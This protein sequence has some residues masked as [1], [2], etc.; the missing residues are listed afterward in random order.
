MKFLIACL[1]NV[2]AQYADTRHNVGFKIADALAGSSAVSFR[3]ER[4]GDVAEVIFKGHVLVVLKPS[5]YMNLSGKAVRYWMQA[6]KIA[7]DRILVVA[8][9]TALPFGKIRLR[10]KGSDG[11]HN[12]FKNIT[13][14]LNTSEYPRLRFGIGSDYGPGQLVQYV[15]GEWNADEQA[16]LPERVEVAVEAIQSF[17]MV[18]L[19]RT[20]TVY[21]SK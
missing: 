15:L 7:L 1:G 8:D 10:S 9:D 18:G 3:T 13:E 17:A 6:E 11:G 20:M 12:G 19:S 4:Y 2:G 5:T 16:V 14:L 21:N